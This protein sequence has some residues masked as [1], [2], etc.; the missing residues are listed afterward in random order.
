MKK[1][2]AV[3]MAVAFVFCLVPISAYADEEKHGFTFPEYYNNEC[4]MKGTIHTLY[5]DV[6]REVRVWTPFNYNQ[7][8]QYELILLM[9]G[10]GDNISAW[11]TKPHTFR[12][13]AITGENLFNWMAYENKCRPFIIATIDNDA[14]KYRNT[15]ME[16]IKSAIKLC[17]DNFST[18]AKSASDD[19]IAAA[20]NHITVGGLSRGSILSYQYMTVY[21][22][23]AGNYICLSGTGDRKALKR[24]FDDKG[25]IIETLF[26]GS[27][28]ADERFYTESYAYY[29]YL[30]AHSK[31][32][33]FVTYNG[34]H[35]WPVWIIGIYDALT[36]IIPQDNHNS[37]NPDCIF[38]NKIKD[39]IK[40][41]CEI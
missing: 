41:I 34:G 22:E 2:F 9:H 32:Q 17:A 14:Q 1:I 40:R 29:K 13:S 15:I 4:P 8:T 7:E 21:P 19:D 24:Y 18:Y 37:T 35:I 36:F 27:G 30:V 12:G 16:D 3:V 20:R 10:D 39:S 38:A 25:D 11:L 23:T 5:L 28:I 26:V 6:E 33:R 31:K